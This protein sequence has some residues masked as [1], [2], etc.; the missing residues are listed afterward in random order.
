MHGAEEFA[1]RIGP[2]VFRSAGD[3]KRTRCRQREEVMRVKRQLVFLLGKGLEARGEPMREAAAFVISRDH[4][5]GLTEDALIERGAA[6]PGVIGDHESEALVL[7]AGPERS[8]AEARMAVHRGAPGIDGRDLLED[9][10]H[11]RQAPRPAADGGPVAVLPFRVHA[12]G[13]ERRAETVLPALGMIGLEITIIDG[14][15]GV[16]AVDEGFELPATCLPAAQ[17]GVGLGRALQGPLFGDPRRRDEDRRV[18]DRS[19]IAAEVESDED[20]SRTLGRVGHVKQ[21]VERRTFLT[22]GP[23]LELGARGLAAEGVLGLLA[24]FDH[25]LGLEL[26]RIWRAAEHVLFDEA[27]DLRTTDFVPH[28]C[29]G[30]L[31]AVGAHERVGQRIRRDLRLF[32]D[33]RRNRSQQ[34][35]G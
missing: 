23:D 16:A 1:E 31:T 6:A 21:H 35:Q 18:F 20:R 12:V 29:V 22:D 3:V 10:E 25:A 9:I 24:D 19:V 14:G 17:G 34:K 26:L 27:K 30:D 28:L 5:D 32:G 33:G 7:R 11:A 4:A 2:A 8:L 15:R 13:R